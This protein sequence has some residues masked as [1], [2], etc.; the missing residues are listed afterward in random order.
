MGCNTNSRTAYQRRGIY[1]D[2]FGL[3][4]CTVDSRDSGENEKAERRVCRRLHYL[5]FYTI[6]KR[7][8]PVVLPW[9]EKWIMQG[10]RTVA[11]KF[12][13]SYLPVI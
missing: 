3:K 6:M 11:F 5:F 8:V 1:W 4:S 7:R 10:H 9:Q 13:S 2:T 12:I